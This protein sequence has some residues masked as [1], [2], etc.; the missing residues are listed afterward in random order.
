MKTFIYNNTVEQ[1]NEV[2][3]HAYSLDLLNAGTNELETFYKVLVQHYPHFD[4]DG[5]KSPHDHSWP[6]TQ[7][8]HAARSHVAKLI[9]DRKTKS[10]VWWTFGV[11]AATL[12][13]LVLTLAE[14]MWSRQYTSVPQ[15]PIST[16]AK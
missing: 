1:Q 11:A 4:T 6:A 7:Q 5:Q 8:W 12:I 13:V 3:C 16:K 15:A 9:E 2:L 14:T 10:R